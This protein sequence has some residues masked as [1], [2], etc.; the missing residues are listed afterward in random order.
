[1]GSVSFLLPAMWMS[2]TLHSAL[3]SIDITIW[4]QQNEQ[5]T[6]GEV[7]IAFD[8]SLSLSL[9]LSLCLSLSLFSNFRVQCTWVHNTVHLTQSVN[10]WSHHKK[11]I[12]TL[13]RGELLVQEWA[14]TDS[15]FYQFSVWYEYWSLNWNCYWLVY[16]D[17]WFSAVMVSVA[18]KPH[19]LLRFRDYC[20]AENF[21]QEFNFVAFVKAIFWLN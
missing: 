8:L 17:I 15:F 19:V 20:I 13:L 10:T 7:S 6:E 14:T 18:L 11:P 4:K 2:S 5:N 9:S 1:M 21:R 3:P 16:P 12:Q